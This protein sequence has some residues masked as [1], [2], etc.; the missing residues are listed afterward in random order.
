MLEKTIDWRAAASGN[1]YGP[2]RIEQDHHAAA[3]GPDG[4]A[5]CHMRCDAGFH[6][7]IGTELFTMQLG[8]ATGQPERIT[9]R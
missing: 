4:F 3:L 2:Q 7:C 1:D 9:G 6:G 8:V 5:S